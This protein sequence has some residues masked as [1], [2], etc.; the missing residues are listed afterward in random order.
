M[1]LSGI[2]AERATCANHPKVETRLRCNKCGKPICARCAVR[3]PVGYRCPSC[4]NEQQRVFYADFKPS[5]YVVAALVALP[6]S[7][8]AGWVLPRLGWYVVL[9]GP[10]VGGGIAEAVR[11]AI[12]GKRGEYTWLVVCGSILLGALPV[13][14]LSLL[15]LLGAAVQAPGLLAS[16]AGGFLRLL[17]GGVYVLTAAGAAYARLRTGNRV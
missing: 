11:W 8:A 2:M 3:T 6:L 14:I 16:L 15:S 4:V 1:G 13:I 5:Y 9:L 7:L 12:R 17:W 10:I